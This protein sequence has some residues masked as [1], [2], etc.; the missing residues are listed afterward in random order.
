MNNLRMYVDFEAAA[1]AAAA[2]GPRAGG[3]EIGE[4]EG[5]EVCS[6]SNKIHQSIYFQMY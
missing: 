1:A 3:R 6:Y 2:S 4:E 5:A